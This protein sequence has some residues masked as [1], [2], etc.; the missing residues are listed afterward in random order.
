MAKIEIDKEKCKG[1]CLCVTECPRG[2]IEMSVEANSKGYLHAKV[3]NE[4]KC[5]GCALCCQMC[6]DMVIKVEK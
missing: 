3:V 5:T 6:P 2:V 4:D 1:C